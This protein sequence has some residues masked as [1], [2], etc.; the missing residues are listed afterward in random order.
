MYT[1]NNDDNDDDNNNIS[2][3]NKYNNLKEKPLVN[4][5]YVKNTKRPLTT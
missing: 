4:T 2:I 1:N 3:I 5:R